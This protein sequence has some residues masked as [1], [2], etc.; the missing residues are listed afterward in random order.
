MPQA[1]KI[2]QAK[3]VKKDIMINLLEDGIVNLP[4]NL[5]I[6]IDGYNLHIHKKLH[7]ISPDAY[8]NLSSEDAQKFVNNLHWGSHKC[9]IIE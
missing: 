7:N 5:K 4:K 1:I 8:H 6:I 9:T 3:I 2:L